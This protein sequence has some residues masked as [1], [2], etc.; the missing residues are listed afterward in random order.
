MTKLQ[1]KGSATDIERQNRSF[2]HFSL[3]PA[4][5]LLMEQAGWLFLND[6]AGGV[7]T[8]LGVNY[9]YTQFMAMNVSGVIA[10][11]CL[12][13]SI[14]YGTLWTTAA[15]IIV[16]FVYLVVRLTTD[17]GLIATGMNNFFGV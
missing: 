9:A 10:L 17:A 6:A 4:L 12:V 1:A 7:S 11:I 15:Y 2:K 8:N 3:I 14:R 16:I 5:M 13:M